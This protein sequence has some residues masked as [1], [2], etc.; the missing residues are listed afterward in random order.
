MKKVILSI[1][2]VFNLSLVTQA[3]INV[4][5]E[6]RF[7]G[8]GSNPDNISDMH[9][10]ASGNIYVTGS[11]Y[12]ATSGYDIITRKYDNNG[13][14]L[15]TSTFNGD[16]NGTDVAAALAVDAN[17]NVFVTGYSYRGGTNYDIT[18]IKYTSAG[19]QSWQNY[20]GNGTSAFDEGKD[21]TVDGNNDIIVTGGIQNTTG[22]NTDYRTIKYTNVGGVAWTMDY[23]NSNN[24]DMGLAVTTDASNSVYVTGHSFVTGQDLNIRTIKYNSAG[25]QQWNTA[26][27]FSTINSIDSPSAIQVNSSGEV[28]V[29]GRVF[30][31]SVS[32]DDIVL[33]KY[34][35]A[36]TVT[37]S[38]II[39]GTANS[40][41]KANRIYLDGSN[42][43][44]LAARMK[45]A[46]S[47]EDFYLGKFNPSLGLI[48][49]D[50][51]NGPS[52]N[53][54][55]AT[56]ITV[57]GSGNVYAS[58]S[59]YSSTSNYDFITVK[60]EGIGGTRLWLTKFNG[61]ANN[62]DQS[63]RISVDAGGNVYVSGDSKGAGTGSDFSTIK[64]C[65]LTT[66]AG[67]DDM[68][69][70]NDNI[71]LNATGGISFSW[72]SSPSLSCTNCA[73]PIA[74]PTT[75]TTYVVS[76]TSGSGC[77]DYDTIEIVVNPLPG[78][79]ITPSGP[80]SFCTG[81]S[82]ILYASGFDSY[83]WNNF[84]TAD[85]LIVT[86]GGNYS[87]TV[88]DSMGC[89]NSTNQMVTVFSLPNVDAGT[90][91]PYCSGGNEQLQAT[92][93]VSFVW[94]PNTDLSS[95]NISNPVTDATS[96]IWY[97]VTGTDGNGCTDEDS[98]FVDVYP[99]P[100]QPNVTYVS[101]THLMVTD[102]TTGVQ[103]YHNGSPINPGGNSQFYTATENGDYWV[104]FTNSNG[105]V[106]PNSD[107]ITVA[108]IIDTTGIDQF[109]SN[110][111]ITL[112]PNPNNG[113]FNIQFNE[114]G[115]DFAIIEI[116]DMTGKLVY[117]E[118][119]T[120]D[121]KNIDLTSVSDGL[122]LV[123]IRINED[124]GM[125]KLIKH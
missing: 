4:Q 79:V 82:V 92:G 29:A 100:G 39:N 67:L 109:I 76:S 120:E 24:L 72:N 14:V 116:M 18:T 121:R 124:Q 46:G 83:E 34:N 44:Y 36:G 62:T 32:D 2:L 77:V 59:S 63:K 53:Y 12:S 114:K 49:A 105:C 11:S 30:N 64:Y 111:G 47:S 113:I 78:P 81:E 117:S 5:W 75:T 13:G 99:L 51:Y 15:W 16:G 119:I 7:T 74:T 108:D 87:V 56:D 112:F 94:S 104:V 110:Y 23:T 37:N 35:A 68:I 28:F 106:S 85:S 125:I 115:F 98:V 71:Q 73:N 61:T 93:A 66:N 70:I 89:E 48:W 101:A 31:G 9:V 122:Y 50:S 97:Y 26:T 96:D 102:S 33:M 58:G 65:Q 10:D 43:V 86:T 57:D 84:S 27:N 19:A 52:N 69:C 41:D 20:S 91:T 88:T 55:E 17:G 80:T 1:V 3:Q 6:T 60:Y 40:V 118:I 25:T 54:D 21:I 123:R 22:T 38:T 45:N 107:T 42:N 103:W 90:A 95:T 8:S